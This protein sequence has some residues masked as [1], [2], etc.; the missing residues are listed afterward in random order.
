MFNIQYLL[1]TDYHK[2]CAVYLCHLTT[3]TA[4][5]GNFDRSSSFLC[6]RQGAMVPIQKRPFIASAF[7][8]IN[9]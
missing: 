7:M 5:R 1:I 6:Q 4:K 2:L 9:N 8:E 3:S